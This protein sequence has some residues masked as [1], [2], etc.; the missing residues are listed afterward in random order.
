M[1]RRPNRRPE[2]EPLLTQWIH[3]IFTPRNFIRIVGALVAIGL[4]ADA[5]RHP[6][7]FQQFA[8]LVIT[9]MIMAAGLML[10]VGKLF[11]KK[12]KGDQ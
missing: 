3:F 10:I 2:R 11:P 4:V 7:D 9:L 5:I 6:E 1:A 8:N 12:K